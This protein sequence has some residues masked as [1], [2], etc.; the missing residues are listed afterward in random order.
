MGR[1]ITQLQQMHHL[2]DQ[3]KSKLS[4][5]CKQD[6]EW[7]NRYLRQFNGIE[8]LYSSDPLDLSLDQLLDT[9]AMVNCGDAQ[10]KGGGAYFGSEYWSRE[11]PARLLDMPIHILEF[12]VIVASAWLWAEQWTGCM[13]YIFCD[14]E[15]V[16]QVLDKE[17]PKDPKMLE[18]LQEFLYI[19]CTR[20]F[21]PIFRKV[22][23]KENA[24][25]DFLSRN[26][27]EL[28]TA[29]Y[30]KQNNLPMRTCVQAPDNL[31]TFKSNW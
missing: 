19:V 29:S 10:L 31:F 20:G 30:F 2:P 13:V 5:G 21:T 18:L 22:G 23:T 8:M 12:W 9:S 11:F 7:W 6:I 15:A 28:Q 4:Q 3:K 16:V 26:H 27:D 17:R 1:L 14:N 24:V 25:A